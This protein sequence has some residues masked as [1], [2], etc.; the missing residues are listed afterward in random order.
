MLGL[1]PPDPEF[2]PQQVIEMAELGALFEEHWAK[3]VQIVRGRLAPVLGA[4]I[5]PEDVVVQAFFIARR[6]WSSYRTQR[7]PQEFLWLYRL[8]ND[9]LI[10]AWRSAT[11]GCRDVALEAPWP[12]QPSVA[13]GLQ[14]ASPGDGPVTEAIRAEV[15]GRIREALAQ[16]R[17]DDREV[18]MLRHFD[19]LPFGEIGVLMNQTENTVAVRYA[20]ALRKLRDIWRRLTGESQP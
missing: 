8:V 18:I 20:R 6:R 4:R 13:L 9:Q 19:R 2:Q 5:D 11:R 12:S 17:I 14:L 3:L 10:E 16:L 1:L 15:A 7:D